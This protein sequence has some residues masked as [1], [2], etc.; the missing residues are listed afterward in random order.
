MRSSPY[1]RN[2]RD[3]NQEV[4]DPVSGFRYP[5]EWVRR[6]GS[7]QEL[8]LV[9]S[10]L[11]VLASSGTVR[12]RG[13]TTGTT[14]AA[15]CKAA[16]LSLSSPVSAVDI[17]T[18][19]RITVTVPVE[20]SGGR[21]IA[22]KYAGDYPQ[23]A[24][25]GLEFV[26]VASRCDDG[27]IIETGEGIGRFE[28]DTPRFAKGNPAVSP[29]ALECILLSADEAM[30]MTGIP[31]ARIHV[32]VPGG[33]EVAKK[34]LNPRIGIHGGISILG[35]TGLVEPWDDHLC[36]SVR[37]RASVPGRVVLTTGRLGLRWSRLLFPDCEVILI[38][39]KIRE[40]LQD[41]TGE[42]VLCGLPALILRFLYPG[43][44]SGTGYDTVEE[45]LQDQV[46]PGKM[47]HAFDLARKN[48]PNLRVV[49][50]DRQG[51]VLGDSG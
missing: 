50:L 28:R 41:R 11:A 44:L 18:P 34:T 3:V 40:V 30:E 2:S 22:R 13:F 25:A 31:G 9:R 29:T 23:D 45:L 4:I 46:F 33:R 39:G 21:A 35:T 26:A 1:S 5:G 12:R 32:S 36:E 8:G 14:A 49:L 10:G 6:C 24:T 7:Q 47:E 16:V 20:S 17:T 48:Y 43:I 38:G 19:C 37:E 42:T 15:A 27:L 51:R